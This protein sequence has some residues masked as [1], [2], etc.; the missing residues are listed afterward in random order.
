MTFWPFLRYSTIALLVAGCV[1]VHRPTSTVPGK[2]S[3]TTALPLLPGTGTGTFQGYMDDQVLQFSSP[4]GT[5]RVKL[6]S[7][8]QAEPKRQPNQPPVM[9]GILLINSSGLG[10]DEAEISNQEW[11]QY[12]LHQQQAGVPAAELQ[13][14]PEALP[15]PEY[16]TDPFY[17]SY[18]VVGISREQ[19]EAFCRWRSRIVTRYV[20]EG[21]H[22]PDS[23]APGYLRCVYRLPTEAEW[24]LAAASIAACTELPVRVE[25][26]AAAYLKRRSGSPASESQISADIARYNAQQPVRSVLNYQQPEPYFLRLPTPGYVYQDPANQL[27]VYHMLGNAAELVQE[28]GLT[29]GGSYRDAPDACTLKARGSYTGPAPTVGFRCACEVSYPNR[30]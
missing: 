6:P 8:W 15:V 13:P 11:R 2:Y 4:D 30:K 12:Q 26:A 14:H 25:P 28:P 5:C 17:R 19:A 18:P 27:G 10:I 23:L 3:A 20:N 21:Q 7:V 24:E 9:P 1:S 29:K 16:Y 22:T